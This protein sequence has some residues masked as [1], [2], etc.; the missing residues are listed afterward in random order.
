MV[1]QAAHLS[2]SRM[3]TAQITLPET[4]MTKHDYVTYK[5]HIFAKTCN[6][7]LSNS[8]VFSGANFFSKFVKHKFPSKKNSSFLK[9]EIYKVARRIKN[10]I[11]EY[12]LNIHQRLPKRMA[13][14][15]EWIDKHGKSWCNKESAI[16]LISKLNLVGGWTNPSEK[17]WSSKWIQLPQGSGWKSK[18]IWVATT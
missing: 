2:S 6:P 12:S 3:T 9:L 15:F 18:N 11:L 4:K 1:I 5:K 8:P 10:A 16:P 13:A 17:I 14:E 7:P